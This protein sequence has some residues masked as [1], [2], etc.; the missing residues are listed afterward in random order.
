MRVIRTEVYFPGGSVLRG[1]GRR[2]L[3]STNVSFAWIKQ[4]DFP[5]GVTTYG[6]PV[7]ANDVP[8]VIDYIVRQEP[9]DWMLTPSDHATA[10][11]REGPRI[12]NHWLV[13]QVLATEI[14]IEQ[15]PP[16]WAT[17]SNILKSGVKGSTVALSVYVAVS[18][19]V[20]LF[21]TIPSAL[22]LIGAAKGTS[23]WLEETIPKM[24]NKAT[25]RLR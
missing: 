10:P 13:E 8:L 18:G 23:K 22:L 24:L 2:R 16:D 3:R 19:D 1:E 7:S 17:L 21:I 25:T 6:Q 9:P 15:S 14:V 4:A 20:M 5:V 11:S 12:L